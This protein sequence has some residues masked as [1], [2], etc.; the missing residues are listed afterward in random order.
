M[1]NNQNATVKT[2][3]IGNQVYTE[4]NQN[5]KDN[6]GNKIFTAGDGMKEGDK[7]TFAPDVKVFRTSG[8]MP[9][10][11]IREWLAIPC[12][13]ERN[14]KKIESVVSISTLT[15]SAYT[16]PNPESGT[17]KNVPFNKFIQDVLTGLNKGSEKVDAILNELKGKSFSI[18]RTDFH[19]PKEWV[20]TTEKKE[21]G[22]FRKTPKLSMIGDKMVILTNSRTVSQL[23]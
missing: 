2:L 18:R 10:G 13:V 8:K 14:G 20:D 16:V 5:E 21:D 3:T 7:V 19:N 9:D 4:A 12:S 22:T 15:G 23:I 17:Q 11:V 1:P 6:L